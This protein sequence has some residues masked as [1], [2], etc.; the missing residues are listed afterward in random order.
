MNVTSLE[1]G[2]R[3]QGQGSEFRVQGSG[4]RVQGSGFRVRVQGSSFSGLK[5]RVRSPG[6]DTKLRHEGF[7][8][9]S[10]P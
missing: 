10:T 4:F 3:V 5:I 8:R 7:Q 1:I 6:A 2:S 9:G